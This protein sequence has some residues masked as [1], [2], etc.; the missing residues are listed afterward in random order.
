MKKFFKIALAFFASIGQISAQEDDVFSRYKAVVNDVFSDISREKVTTGLLIEKAIPYVSVN[1][2]DGSKYCDTANYDVFR[3]LYKQYCLAHYDYTNVTL[4]Q[5]FIESAYTNEDEIPIGLLAFDYNQISTDAVLNNKIILDTISGKIIDNSR[6]TE[7][8]LDRKTCVSLSPLVNEIE[9]GTY[10]FSFPVQLCIGNRINEIQELLVNF[11]DG[12]GFHSV[13]IGQSVMAYYDSPGQKI[14]QT[15]IKIA[16]K[17]YCTLSSL[18]VH[19]NVETESFLKSYSLSLEPDFGPASYIAGNVEAEYAIYERCNG[20]GSLRKPYL[21][22]SGF[23]PQDN[24]RLVDKSGKIN[25]YKVSNKNGYLDRLRNDGYDI[26]IYRSKNSAE[27]IIDN[28]KNLVSFIQKINKEKTSNN[29]LIIAGASMGGLVVRYALTY[30]EYYKIDHQTKLFISVDSPQEGANI[31]LGIQYMLK[32]LNSDLMEVVDKLKD[33]E[34]EM[35][36]SVAAKEM[37][38]YHHTATDGKTAK[39]SNKRDQFLSSLNSIGSFPKQCRTIALSMGSG[40]GTGQ[41]FSAGAKLFEKEPN[42]SFLVASLTPVP[43]ITWEC[44]VYAVPNQANHLIY[45][46]SANLKMCMRMPL[47]GGTKCTSGGTVASR[48]VYVNNTMPIDNAPGSIRNLH[49]LGDFKGEG[50]FGGIDGVELIEFLGEFS[51]DSHPDNFIPSYSSLGLRNISNPHVN[52]KNYLSSTAGVTKLSNNLYA[53][54]DKSN[55]SWFDV[56]YVEDK[57]LDHIY[58]KDK[59]GVFS[60][61]MISVMLDESSSENIYLENI[62]VGNGHKKAAEAK[63]SVFIGNSVDNDLKNDGDVILESGSVMSALANEKIQILPGTLI[64]KGS[65]FTAKIGN[66]TYCDESNGNYVKSYELDFSETDDIAEDDGD[67]LFAIIKDYSD[68]VVMYP[69]PVTEKL[70]VSSNKTDNKVII[71]DVK[72]KKMLQEKF[73]KNVELTCRDFPAGTYVVKVVQGN[74]NVVIKQVVKQ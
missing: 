5:D 14:I 37:L 41:G 16:G 72:G 21:I 25:L 29:E 52:I 42:I 32:Y 70:F 8:I 55:I 4:N 6:A 18:N 65:S 31:P 45:T 7:Q 11:D 69:N 28:A 61:E 58:D 51:Y 50:G 40:N 74:G 48:N 53:K 73:Q 38:L 23:D 47:G 19:G 67:N 2:Y 59:E 56:M 43:R 15:R 39:C 3:K 24:N 62:T 13:N 54:S 35:L 49:N 66:E 26:V 9:E 60:E 34:D 33:A 71:Y 22:V 68:A 20:D 44:S 46:E 1:Q 17:S 12:S 57:N 64:K 63:K 30:M 36:N 10:A 27:S